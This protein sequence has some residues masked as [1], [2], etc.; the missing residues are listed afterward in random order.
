M[1]LTSICVWFLFVVFSAFA[2]A[3]PRRKL[4]ASGD[5]SCVKGGYPFFTGD[6]PGLFLQEHIHL[7]PRGRGAVEEMIILSTQ[8]LSEEGD[9]IQILDERAT[10][11][12]G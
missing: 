5:I 8:I 1:Q 12:H 9:N 2:T 7:G 6:Y 11:M 10:R 4:P 3:L